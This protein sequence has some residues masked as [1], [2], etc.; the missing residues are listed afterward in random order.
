MGE[1]ND[2]FIGSILG[3]N[4]APEYLWVKI[5]I[6]LYGVSWVSGEEK[7]RKAEPFSVTREPAGDTLDKIHF[8]RSVFLRHHNLQ[9]T[10]LRNH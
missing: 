5:M 9:D 10:L 2:P 6:L 3:E 4:N 8:L 1:N 7:L